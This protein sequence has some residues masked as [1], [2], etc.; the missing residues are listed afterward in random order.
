MARYTKCIAFVFAWLVLAVNLGAQTVNLEIVTTTGEIKIEK[1]AKE[2]KYLTLM[3][4]DQ[5]SYQ[6]ASVKN[7]DALPF[8]ETVEL[9]NIG[10]ILDYSFLLKAK[11]LKSLHTASCTIGDLRFLEKMENLEYLSLDVY[12][13]PGALDVLKTTPINLGKLDR[14]EYIAFSAI[15]RTIFPL[16]TQVKN[17]PYICLSNNNIKSF[18]ASEVRLLKQY[19]FIN[20]E[21]NPI[22]ENPGK[23]KKLAGMK[24]RYN[25]STPI[26]P[27]ILKKYYI[28]N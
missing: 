17:K 23:Q 24:V 18:S 7:L 16:F 4:S 6:I 5:K 26:P 2:T 14:L 10:G 11:G 13:R 22:A 21:F 9:A 3:D 28:T 1:F 15:P 12:V 19:S 27:E 8:L 25:D 20:L